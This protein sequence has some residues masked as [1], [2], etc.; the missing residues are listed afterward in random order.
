MGLIVSLARSKEERLATGDPR[1]SLEER[2]P[3][4]GSD[5][6]AVSKRRSSWCRRVFLLPWDARSL[7]AEAESKEVA[8]RCLGFSQVS[9]DAS[10]E[11]RRQLQARRKKRRPTP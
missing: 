3:N 4:K 2:Y 11:D 8:P 10:T 1:L 6:T 9:V 7:L 5:V